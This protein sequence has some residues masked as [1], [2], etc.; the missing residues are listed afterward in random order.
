MDNTLLAEHVEAMADLIEKCGH[1]TGRPGDE[2]SGFCLLGAGRVV[3][4]V[5]AEQQNGLPAYVQFAWGAAKY[6]ADEIT[7]KALGL[8]D[9]IEVWHLNDT[10]N[11]EG[12]I[13]GSRP[14]NKN[15]ALELLD[16]R[17][18]ELRNNG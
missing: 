9:Y 7:T 5:L 16:A 17:A 4:G 11:P 3:R 18:K 13:F 14:L 15:T 8:A 1:V 6:V 10:G 12:I 2:K